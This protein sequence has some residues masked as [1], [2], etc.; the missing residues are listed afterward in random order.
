MLIVNGSSSVPPEAKG[1]VLALGNFDGVHRGH[2][3]LISRAK[4]E[5]RRIGRPAGVLLFEPHPREFFA[6]DEQHFHLTPHEEKLAVL[7]ELGL[8]LAVVLPFDATLAGLDAGRFIED[9]LVGALFVSHVVVGY[10]FF[11]GRNRTGSAETLREAGKAHG[12]AVTVV[13]PVAERGEPFSSTAI[14]L[15]L[16]EGDVR[17]A[18]HAL[19]RQWRVRGPVIGGAQRG[20]GLGFPTANVAMPKGTGLGH[21]IFAVRVKLD[22]KELEGAAYLGTRPTFD[23]GKPVLEVFLFD[24]D[25]KIYGH[26]IEVSF[27]EKVRSDRKFATSEEL[28][29]QMEADCAKARQIL[30]AEPQAPSRG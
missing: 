5:A 21:G 17:G 16:A 15:L 1:A 28:V 24:F 11:F 7:D 13:E 23:D 3:V 20:T 29:R 6:P 19:G 25:E 8:D 30:A 10:H 18:A 22:G 27:V 26:E 2:R 4:E 14:R 12:F 9:I